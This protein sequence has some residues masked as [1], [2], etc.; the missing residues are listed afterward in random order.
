MKLRYL[1]H[2]SFLIEGGGVRVVTDPYGDI[3]L[4]F[5]RVEA[6]GVTVSHAHSDHNNAA[7]VEGDRK[8][9]FS[10][11]GR[12]SLGK[13]KIESFWCA[14]DACGGQQRGK[15]LVFCF[16][17]DG[18]RVCHLG[19]VGEPFSQALCRKICPADVLLIPVGGHYTIDAQEAKRFIQAISPKVAIPMHYFVPGLKVDVAPP[20]EFLRL[21]P[22]ALTREGPLDLNAE[23]EARKGER[24]TSVILLKRFAV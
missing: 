12:F 7:A 19:D 18:L 11:S 13:M 10:S 1:G 9:V 16:E 24:E 5:P 23:C 6:D 14:H 3:G 22:A 8:E 21:F 17:A 2:A 4:P 20:D 15:S